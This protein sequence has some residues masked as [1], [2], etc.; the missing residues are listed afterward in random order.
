[1]HVQASVPQQDGRGWGMGL[2]RGPVAL[3]DVAAAHAIP[4]ELDGEEGGCGTARGACRLMA[5][6]TVRAKHSSASER[7]MRGFRTRIPPHLRDLD[8][9]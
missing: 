7:I 8:F 3:W 9:L 1:M 4:K 2:Q 5:D 6:G